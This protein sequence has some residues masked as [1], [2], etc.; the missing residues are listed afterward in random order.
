MAM[1]TSNLRTGRIQSTVGTHTSNPTPLVTF[2][3][4]PGDIDDLVSGSFLMSATG[5]TTT[6][7]IPVI[8][9]YSAAYQLAFLMLPAVSG[10]SNANTFTLQPLTQFLVPATLAEQEVPVAGFDNGTY[11]EVI[12]FE[13]GTFGG[14]NVFQ[15]GINGNVS[16]FTASGNK[17][18]DAQVIKLF[19]N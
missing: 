15:F 3:P 13:V 17:G 18:I 12:S 19:L 6:I 7:V 16:G 5:F 11:A 9:K 1:I 8:Y 14:T 10:V 2:V 4:T